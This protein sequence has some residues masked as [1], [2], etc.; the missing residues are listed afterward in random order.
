MDSAISS[1][2]G[3]WEYSTSMDPFSHSRGS[4]SPDQSGNDYNGRIAQEE[5]HDIKR[6]D[7]GRRYILVDGQ[8]KV[9]P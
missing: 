2:D 7:P 9:P 4:F 1:H 8:S 3:C 6:L 5:V